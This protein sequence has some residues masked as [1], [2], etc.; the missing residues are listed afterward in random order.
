MGGEGEQFLVSRE[1][2]N[3]QKRRSIS[4]FEQHLI[5]LA[6]NKYSRVLSSGRKY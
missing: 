3:E 1:I 5:S 2:I 6:R 4:A